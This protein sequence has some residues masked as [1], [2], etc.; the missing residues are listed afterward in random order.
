MPYIKQAD[1]KIFGTTLKKLI[2][3]ILDPTKFGTRAKAG[4]LNYLFTVILK[5]VLDDDKRYDTANSLVGALECC[6]LELYRRYIAPYEDEKI[7]ENGDVDDIL[8]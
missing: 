7:K 2:E 3:L 8:E 1:R 4:V 6:K 5:S